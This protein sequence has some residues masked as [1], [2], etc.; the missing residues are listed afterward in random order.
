MN[1]DRG[2]RLLKTII[3]L[4]VGIFIFIGLQKLLIPK[5][6]YPDGVWEAP[7]RAIS[8]FYEEKENSIDVLSIGTSAFVYGFSPM[9]IYDKYG[10]KAY[11]LSTPG[12]PI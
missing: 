1:K 8:G 7:D 3:F 2:L 4:G 5:W 12:Q 10:I 9:Y 6:Y 11:N